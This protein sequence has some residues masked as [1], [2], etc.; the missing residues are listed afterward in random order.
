MI[1]ECTF[2]SEINN[3]NPEHNLY[4][5]KKVCLINY[6]G[7]RYRTAFYLVNL[8]PLVENSECMMFE[9]QHVLHAQCLDLKIIKTSFEKHCVMRPV[10]PMKQTGWSSTDWAIN[11]NHVYPKVFRTE[12][13]HCRK[14]RGYYLN[15]SCEVYLPFYFGTCTG[16]IF[17]FCLLTL[18]FAAFVLCFYLFLAEPDPEPCR[19]KACSAIVEL[20]NQAPA[21]SGKLK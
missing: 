20:S 12:G 9:T 17:F 16:L 21:I 13:C 15:G 7:K 10:T 3:E 19:T 18:L 2:E 4:K 1:C 6:L 14:D 8:L 5:I 11:N